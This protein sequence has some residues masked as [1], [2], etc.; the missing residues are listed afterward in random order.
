MKIRHIIIKLILISI[1]SFLIYRETGIGTGIF[2]FLTIL[3]IEYLLLCQ[4]KQEKMLVRL[5]KA[6]EKIL[7]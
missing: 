6:I 1:I 3:E 5:V 4:V 7:K 2:V